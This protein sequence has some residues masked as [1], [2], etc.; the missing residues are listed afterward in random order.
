MVASLDMA[1]DDIIRNNSRHRA[2]NDRPSAGRGW[3][4][5]AGAGGPARR[6][7]SRTSFRDAMPYTAPP[8][9]ER[10][11]E[12]EHSSL[13]QFHPLSLLLADFYAIIKIKEYA[14]N[15]LSVRGF[16]ISV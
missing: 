4:P 10:L 2:L 16:L 9:S 7:P 11:R 8:V 15:F 3:R 14:F 1:L 12:K 6:F 13:T 5:P